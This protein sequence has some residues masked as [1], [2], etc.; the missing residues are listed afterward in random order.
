MGEWGK[1]PQ[2][3]PG[4]SDH[5]PKS[6]HDKR[7]FYEGLIVMTQNIYYGFTQ[8]LGIFVSL[9][10]ALSFTCFDILIYYVGQRHH[11]VNILLMNF[12]VCLIFNI[13][14]LM[15]VRPK[16]PR[17][18]QEIL[19]LTLSGFLSGSGSVVLMT[20]II[21][22]EPG[23]A[24]SLYFTLPLFVIVLSAI[25]HKAKPNIW[26][27]AVAMISVVGV[28]FI[29]K[30]S[31]LFSQPSLDKTMSNLGVLLALVAAF[32][33]GLHVLIVQSLQ[34][35]NTHNFY[36]VLSSSAQGLVESLLL[37]IYFDRVSFKCS[38]EIALK[39][40]LSGVFQFG[41]FSLL[42]FAIK[43][44][45]PVIV[46]I[47]MTT[48]VVFTFLAQYVYLDLPISWQSIVGGILIGTS[49]IAIK[50]IENCQERS[51]SDESAE[52]LMQE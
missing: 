23:N 32:C 35:R 15:A 12:S 4:N 14:I 22:T 34:E 43:I 28:I 36:I 37:C 52:P 6:I 18:F 3:D 50:L 8:Y 41:G 31:F 33:H 19:L 25:I 39:V 11:P 49:C 30:P 20:S 13:G 46:T 9:L 40:V 42:A 47:V 27:L 24:V 26:T 21:I 38:S 1:Q 51:Q 2:L 48:E 44:E 10:S 17:T 45:R 29:A 5:N 16:I 7:S